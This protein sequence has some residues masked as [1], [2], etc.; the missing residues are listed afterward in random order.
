M[1]LTQPQTTH[2]PKRYH[3]QANPMY[4][5]K[6]VVQKLGLS[7]NSIHACYN[8]CVLFKRE[9]SDESTFPKCNKS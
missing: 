4:H 6:K 8:G 1:E 9:L 3:M 2:G 5:A 7:Y